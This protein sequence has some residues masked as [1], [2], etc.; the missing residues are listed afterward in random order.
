MLPNIK[1]YSHDDLKQWFHAHEEPAFRADQ[2][3]HWLYKKRVQTFNDMRNVSKSAIRLLESSFS[4]GPIERG[5]VQKSVDGSIKYGF[6]MSDQKM[7]ESVLMPHRDHHT[8]C[9]SSQVGCAMACDFCMTG[10]MGFIRNLE[11]GEIVEQVL[12]AWKDLS[13]EDSIRNVVFMGMG[14][15]FHNYENVM[16]ALEILTSSK[17]LN[18][19]S[20]R[21]TVST[22]G[23]LP[24]I[25][26][27]GQ[28]SVR[29]SLA[30]SLNGVT[31]EVR[32]R[33]MPVNKTY[34]LEKLVETCKAFPLESRK[35]ITFEYILIRDVTDSLSDAKALIRLLHG[36]KFKVN[37]IPF[38]E[39]GGS[40]Y[41]RPDPD[42]IEEFQR[43]L[44]N[45]GV[46]ATQRI[47]KGQDI[48]GACGQLITA[49]RRE[50][51]VKSVG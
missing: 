48:Q 9:V 50:S 32:S 40:P 4:L 37:L 36:L 7:V 22:S 44:L 49:S 27:F 19:S 35:R 39:T 47:S 31:D 5:P 30:I 29:A 16:K 23:L 24:Q 11:P 14:E 46:V 10:K 17:G 41:K 15:P 25:Q 3:Y 8:V 21:V 2:V 51:S 20:R 34:N 13:A 42:T 45:H 38:N 6:L 12:E 43:Y 28:E 33:L 18:F 1:N 26:R